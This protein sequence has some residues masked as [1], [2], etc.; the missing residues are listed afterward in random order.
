MSSRGGMMDL[1]GTRME[2]KSK[3]RV[4]VGGVIWR[5]IAVTVDFLFWNYSL[6]RDNIFSCSYNSYNPNFNSHL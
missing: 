1:L 3:V 2:L 5:F 4:T 6:L